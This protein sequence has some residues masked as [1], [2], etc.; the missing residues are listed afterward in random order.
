MAPKAGAFNLPSI[1]DGKRFRQRTIVVPTSRRPLP[2]GPSGAPTRHL[3]MSVMAQRAEPPD[4]LTDLTLRLADPPDTALAEDVLVFEAQ[5]DGFRLIGGMG[6]GAGWAD[7]V[8]LRLA[9]NPTFAQAWKCA[10]PVRVSSTVPTHVAGPYWATDAVLVPVGHAH[11]VVFG[12]PSVRKLSDAVLVGEAAHAVADTGGATAEKL[13]ADELEL[14]HAMRELTSY[15]PTDV[16][17]T[18]R[19]I[20][21]V[22]AR[23]LSCDVA[24]VR[25]QSGGQAT[26]EV[27]RLGPGEGIDADPQIAGRDAGEY[28]E[29][30]ATMTDAMV[31]QTVG[32]DPEVWKQKVVSRMTLPIGPEVDL[33]AL[34]LGHAQGHERGFTS[35]CQR[36]GRALA[37]SAEQ[38]LNQAIVHEQLTAER[39]SFQRATMTDSLTGIGNR[40]AWEAALLSPP[41]A[42][43]HGVYAVISA[44][45]DGL[46]YINDHY[47][48]GA[49]DA[50]IRGAADMLLSTLRASDVLCRVG[51]DEFLA[52]LPDVDANAVREIV[53]RI[54]RAMASWRLTEHGL[55]PRLSLGWAVF[56]GDWPQTVRT[57]DRRMYSVKRQHNGVVPAERP[58]VGR[59]AAGRRRRRSDAGTKPERSDLG[60]PAPPPARTSAMGARQR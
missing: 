14:V 55:M 30:A 1:S 28:L 31:E 32:P 47:G 10:M 7:I 11:L 44:D 26:L 54:E 18:A 12:G 60:P 22:A 35:L 42:T 25:V 21:T 41:R 53:R 8:E 3:I 34:A 33:G 16:R 40:A 39:H 5:P 23:A 20:A 9:D 51:G 59:V 13:L 15:Q 38:L 2:S 46:K 17:E 45:L 57:A 58:A 37:Q 6:R 36:I 27:V 29:A 49:G 4:H 52:L 19:H 43:A 50:V 48:H 56:D 24:A